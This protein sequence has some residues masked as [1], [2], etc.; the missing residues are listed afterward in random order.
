LKKKQSSYRGPRKHFNEAAS[1][2]PRQW[3]G[4]CLICHY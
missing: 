1:S 3:T 4:K 2:I